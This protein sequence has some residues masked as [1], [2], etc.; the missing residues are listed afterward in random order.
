MRE[1]RAE[2]DFVCFS[3]ASSLTLLIFFCLASSLSIPLGSLGSLLPCIALFAF[4]S[5]SLFPADL[6]AGEKF[7]VPAREKKGRLLGV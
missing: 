5:K 1:E 4:F 3:F 7:E 6:C 2:F